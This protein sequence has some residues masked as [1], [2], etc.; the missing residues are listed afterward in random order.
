MELNE[1][2][3]EHVQPYKKVKKWDEIAAHDL[4][5][6]IKFWKSENVKYRTLLK[7]FF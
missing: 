2:N 3:F 7:E 4:W 5:E 6:S 1:N